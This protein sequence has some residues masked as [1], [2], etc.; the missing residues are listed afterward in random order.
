MTTLRDSLLGKPLD[1]FSRETRHSVALVAFLAWIGLGADGLS[2]ACYGPEEAYLALGAHTHLGLYLAALTAITVFIIAVAYNQVIELF[3]SGGGGYKVATQLLG[4]RAGLVS[5]SALIVDYVLTV[6]I[7]VASGVDALFSLLPATLGTFKLEVEIGLTLALLYLNLRGMKESIRALLPIFLGFVV[8]HT[9]LIVYGVLAHGDRLPDL[10]PQTWTETHGMSTQMGWLAVA[11]LLLRAYSLG[12]GTY[13][14]IEAVS[15]NVQSLAE[16][17][18]RTGKWTMFYMALSLAFTAGGIIVL[19]L[20]WDARHVEGQTLNAVTFDSI[21]ASFGWGS[22]LLNQAALIVVLAFEAGLLLVAANT[23][24][25]GG[26]AVLANMAVESWMPHQFR[27]LSSR[28]VTQNGLILMAVAAVIV[29]MITRG[30]VSVLVVL[31]SINVFLTFTLS[32]AGLLRYWWMH[33]E[34]SNWVPRLLLSFL[35]FAVCGGI[36]VITTVEKFTEGGWITII[37]TSIVIA[38]GWA[39]RRHYDATT[40]RVERAE[41]VHAAPDGHVGAKPRLTPE[42]PAAAFIVGKSRCGLIHASR[43]VLKLWPG[44][45]KNFLVVSGCAVDVRSYGGDQALEALKAAR[46]KDMDFYMDLARQN[47]VA[48]KYYL[49]FGVDGV[50]EA[51]KLCRQAREEFPNI[52]FFASKLM[53]ED[54]TWVTRM[55]HNQIVYAIQRRLNDEGMHM[56]VL[57]MEIPEGGC[58]PEEAEPRQGRAAPGFAGE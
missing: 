16:P 27:N 9:L 50:E 26:P 33:R 35:G 45:Y 23:G 52:V 44:F 46:Q 24:F 37:I 34:K 54:E 30:Q 57:P 8:T 3:P 4:P 51:V 19:Y 43:M 55:L 21:I 39:I 14:G 29:L 53:F 38:T 2:S 13:T 49:G 48:S 15:N 58:A 18:V 22:A 12:G 56:V 28:L 5:G 11:A 10:I 25:L 20:L 7:S 36:L 32:L 17:R 41:V 31:Y 42:R 47:G 40:A 1:P 6:A